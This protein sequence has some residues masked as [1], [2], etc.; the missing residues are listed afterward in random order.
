[1]KAQLLQSA[2]KLA[3][4][5]IAS[6]MLLGVI[7][8]GM[9]SKPTT[10][11]AEG[12]FVRLL[13][14]AETSVSP[15]LNK[16]KPIGPRE[17]GAVQRTGGD[18]DAYMRFDLESLLD[19][20]PES[21]KQVSLRFTVLRTSEKDSI[22][23][24]IYLMPENG[25]NE[26]MTYESRP[27]SLG[28]VMI[29]QVSVVP[30]SG[31]TPSVAEVDLTD[32]ARKWM[33]EGRSQVSLHL[34]APKSGEVVTYAAGDYEDPAFRSCLKIVTGTAHDPDTPDLTKAW[35]SAGAAVEKDDGVRYDVF[36]AGNGSDIYLKFSIKK[37]NI[38]GAVYLAYLQLGLMEA[39]PDS[40]LKIY[41]LE[42]TGWSNET[43]ESGA[44]PQ[45]REQLIYHGNQ[46]DAEKLRRIDL[47]DL[48]NESLSRG[49]TELA[50]RVACEGGGSVAFAGRDSA[51]APS[52]ALRVSDD[53]NMAAA[54]EAAVYGLNQNTDSENICSDLLREYTA[55]DGTRA[56]L[57]WQ[58]VDA[59]TGEPAR[60]TLSAFGAVT[61]PR[62]FRHSRRILATATITSGSVTRQRSYYLTVTPE[63]KPDYSQAEFKNMLCLGDA[64]AELAQRFESFR[65]AMHSRWIAGRSF[66]C[67]S[68]LPDGAMVLN[69]AADPNRQNYL[70]LKLW[71]E[72][73]FDG[74]EICSLQNPDAPFIHIIR[75]KEASEE[76]GFLYLTY[77]LPP[78][79]TQNARFVSLR[80]TAPPDAENVCDL[81]GAYVTQTPYFDPMCFAEQGEAVV[82]KNT[83]EDFDFSR[84]IKK[85]CDAAQQPFSFLTSREEVAVV[86]EGPEADAPLTVLAQNGDEQLAVSSAKEDGTVHIQRETPYYRAYAETKVQSYFDGGMTAVDYDKYHIFRNRDEAEL[87]LPWESEGLSGLYRDLV[88]GR[89]Y[90]FLRPG[91]M[92]DDSILPAGTEILDGTG[93]MLQPDETVVLTLVAEPLQVADWRVSELNGSPVSAVKLS[94]VMKLETVT[95]RNIGTLAEQQVLTVICGVYE[96]GILTAM[97]HKTIT[98]SQGETQQWLSLNQPVEIQPGQ[99][100]KIFIE[101]ASTGLTSMIPKLEL[102]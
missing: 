90:A 85:L 24:R 75:P 70:T 89:Y 37:E 43:L 83:A 63:E 57:S 45:G 50:L 86:P 100:L 64:K 29:A 91:E 41:R 68:L 6:V 67:R 8:I 79:Y 26:N 7:P 61:Q 73:P 18:Y 20:E 55:D 9:I 84:F 35:L 14:V 77:A 82:Q 102:P 4:M 101:P 92:A 99:I 25:W 5:L 96:R 59:D 13:P 93:R 19:K 58:A 76:D 34:A 27:S 88:S 72:D 46:L 71:G 42:N 47:T 22:P 80:L 11:R 40:E 23:I 21:L 53:K 36:D 44:L 30:E 15:Q 2:K 69:L 17:A 98:V 95:I 52:L 56:T 48:L 49:E 66:S 39:A 87:P 54:V 38:Q 97:E 1:M 28:E 78:E 62:W 51:A 32:Y 60:D 3:V 10:V 94:K 74:V 33:E 16:K 12:E 31:K 65:T 81:Y